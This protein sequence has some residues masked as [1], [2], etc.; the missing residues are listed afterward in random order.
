MIQNTQFMTQNTVFVSQ[1]TQNTPFT[2]FMATVDKSKH[3][4]LENMLL[5]Q[6]KMGEHQAKCSSQELF[7]RKC[8]IFEKRTM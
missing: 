4:C 5:G 1:I 3:L 2:T 8:N 7:A 6:L